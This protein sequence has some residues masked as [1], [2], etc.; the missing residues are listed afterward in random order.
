MCFNLS[1]VIMQAEKNS[2][3]DITELKAQMLKRIG[4]ERFKRYFYYLSRFIG[5]R[6]SKVDFDRLC[7]RTLGRENL[8]LHN[9]IIK[10]I[11]KNACA[12]KTPPPHHEVGPT[13]PSLESGKSLSV[14]VVEG[15]GQGCFVLQN[16]NSSVPIR[17]NGV[18]LPSSPRKSRSG[19]RDQRIRDRPS[20]LGLNGRADS[21]SIQSTGTEDSGGK[22]VE[23]GDVFPCDYHRP[24]QQHQQGLAE[25][26]D[27]EDRQKIKAVETPGSLHSKEPN[28]APVV[29]DG[30]EVEQGSNLGCSRS[31]L[32]AP[33]G[34]PFCSSS[35]GGARKSLSGTNAGSFD[36]CYNSGVLSDT[37]TLRKRMEQ[38]ATDQG[39][40]AVTI[41]CAN[42]LNNMLDLYLR[43]LIRSCVEL[44]GARS[45]NNTTKYPL[46]KQQTHGRLV[47]GL[48]PSSHLHIQSGL[49]TVEGQRSY[50]PISLVDFKVAMELNPQQLG[51]D[52]PLLLEKI[53][54]QLF[55]E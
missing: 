30:E 39:L 38:I 36:G 41:Q 3:T 8:P 26:P 4:P 50:G 15:H 35:F 19:I 31:S 34:I 1:Q 55:E 10:S 40:G 16:Q 21:A 42:V 14:V 7:Y 17:S 5:Q 12:A 29:E 25:Q 13:K 47:N 9:Q 24:L 46:Q 54:M 20:P 2:R 52:W 28:D 51:E 22:T 49:G 33:L 27:H 6:L 48:W 43:R 32:L 44:V 53:S 18:V 23:N 11:L 45:G 37:G